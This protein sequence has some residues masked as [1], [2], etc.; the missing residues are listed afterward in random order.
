M[1]AQLLV[2]GRS[3]SNSISSRDLVQK[4]GDHIAELQRENGG[5][6]NKGA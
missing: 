6:T 1:I 2:P 4:S 3:V 5:D